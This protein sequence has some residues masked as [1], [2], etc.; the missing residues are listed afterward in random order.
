[1]THRASGRRDRS[2][3]GT[4]EGRGGVAGRGGTMV[5]K[6]EDGDGTWGAEVGGR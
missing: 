2:G 4:T 1:M 3:T 6:E 5:I